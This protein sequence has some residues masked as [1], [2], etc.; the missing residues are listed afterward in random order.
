[1]KVVLILLWKAIPPP[2]FFFLLLF[3]LLHFGLFRVIIFSFFDTEFSV[4]SFRGF[5]LVESLRDA[6]NPAPFRLQALTML[7]S[8]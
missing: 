5:Y 8:N 2:F 6:S 3:L 4:M 7:I 1:M